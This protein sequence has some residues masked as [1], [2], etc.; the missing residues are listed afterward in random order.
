MASS[1][2]ALSPSRIAYGTSFKDSERTVP[3][4]SSV[5]D[6]DDYHSSHGY[7]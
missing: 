1:P 5:I 7:L 3:Q 4:D 2:L 6:L